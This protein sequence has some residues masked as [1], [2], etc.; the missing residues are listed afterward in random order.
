[1]CNEIRRRRRKR[2]TEVWRNSLQS[3]L[4]SEFQFTNFQAF[5]LARER[6]TIYIT[7]IC[8]RK[9]KVSL[10]PPPFWIIIILFPVIVPSHAGVAHGAANRRMFY[11]CMQASYNSI[12]IHTETTAGAS[13]A[14]LHAT[15]RCLAYLSG[16]LQP[17]SFFFFFS[18]SCTV[19]SGTKLQG[20]PKKISSRSQHL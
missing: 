9:F 7:K 12:H 13:Y 10:Q 11:A 5:G 19:F 3:Y 1:M 6:E 16:A 15:E 18:N 4:R 17:L 8:C 2:K 20:F 14:I